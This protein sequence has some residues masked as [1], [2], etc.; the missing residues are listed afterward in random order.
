MIK[1]LKG[2]VDE[3][4]KNEVS[5]KVLEVLGEKE[6]KQILGEKAKLKKWEGYWLKVLENC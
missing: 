3:K 5:K 1:V 4:I 6:G 2:D